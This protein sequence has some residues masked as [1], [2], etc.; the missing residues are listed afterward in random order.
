[1]VQERVAYGINKGHIK[2]EE[3][4]QEINKLNALIQGELVNAIEDVKDDSSSDKQEGI[5]E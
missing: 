2:P 1:M 4:A 3:V 5:R